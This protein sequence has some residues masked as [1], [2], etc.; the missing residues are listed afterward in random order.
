MAAVATIGGALQVARNDV[1][2]GLGAFQSLRAVG[3]G[4]TIE[5]NRQLTHVDGLSALER[6]DGELRVTS[7]PMLEHLDGFGALA[8]VNGSVTISSL[9][10]L[11]DVDGLAQL[12]TVTGDLSVND[13]QRLAHLNGLQRMAQ[14]GD[15]RIM[16]NPNLAD[17]SGLG[18]LITVTDAFT[19]EYNNRPMNSPRDYNREDRTHYHNTTFSLEAF[20][21]LAAVGGQFRISNERNITRVVFPALRTVG[22]DFS[23]NN[24]PNA[25][26]LTFDTLAS[27]GGNFNL[28]DMANMTHVSFAALES[29]GGNFWLCPDH[30]EVGSFDFNRGFPNLV[31][32]LRRYGWTISH[33][34]LSLRSM[35]PPHAPCAVPYVVP[36]RDGCC[37]IGA[38]NLMLWPIHFL[39]ILGL[40]RRQLRCRLLTQLVRRWRQRR[41]PAPE[42]DRVRDRYP[43]AR[44]HQSKKR[45]NRRVHNHGRAP[46]LAAS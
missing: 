1:L 34:F 42:L 15:C 2:A 32:Q 10:N 36:M 33:V 19:V 21:S 3:G 27:V 18:N 38:C 4:V 46:G 5:N 11:T 8:V 16:S 7:N 31:R 9:P 22:E 13:N 29:V 35:P 40:A 37:M 26:D 41:R 23:M 30:P 25:T 17:F 45:G 28:R 39:I 14:L 12:A 44:T 43:I 24:L 6:V 20:S